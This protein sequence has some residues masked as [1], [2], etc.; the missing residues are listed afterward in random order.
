MSGFVKNLEN[1]D[2][3]IYEGNPQR[4]II[5]D[6]NFKSIGTYRVGYFGKDGKNIMC[7]DFDKPLKLVDGEF[8]DI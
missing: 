4:A 5:Y 1:G 2:T 8:I 7:P 6:K 3:V